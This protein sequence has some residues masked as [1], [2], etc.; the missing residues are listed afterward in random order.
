MAAT[1]NI[2]D[3]TRRIAE[4]LRDIKPGDIVE[5]LTGKIPIRMGEQK[6]VRYVPGAL[7][8]AVFSMTNSRLLFPI[9]DG[10]EQE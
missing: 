5:F 6:E 7:G 2:A 3:V 10:A 1:D 9:Q 4:S 8:P